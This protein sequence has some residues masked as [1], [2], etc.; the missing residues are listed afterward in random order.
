MWWPPNHN[1]QEFYGGVFNLHQQ[2]GSYQNGAL[3]NHA[4]YWMT[5]SIFQIHTRKEINI[6]DGTRVINKKKCD[7]DKSVTSILNYQH[8]RDPIL[9]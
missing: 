1:T 3:Q 6:L 5:Y 8:V 9:I 4:A 7:D 2:E